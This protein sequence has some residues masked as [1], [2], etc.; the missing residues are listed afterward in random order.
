MHLVM[1]WVAGDSVQVYLRDRR[2]VNEIVDVFTQAARGLAAVHAAGFVH[3]DF[4]PENAIV[5]RDGRVRVLDF[6]LAWADLDRH[7]DD[8]AGTPRYMAPEQLTGGALTPAVD[9]YAL[10]VA[11]R[12]ALGARAG[13]GVAVDVPRWLAQI[14]ARGTAQRPDERF[15][16]LDE[17]IR[18][19]GRDPARVLRRRLAIASWIAA[20]VS[21]L[22][23]AWLIW[24]HDLD[25]C[26]TMPAMPPGWS[27]A[28]HAAV[29]VRL[30]TLGGFAVSQ[31]PALDGI[32]DERERGWGT[33]NRAACQAFTRGGVTA[34]IYE[35][36]LTCLARA[37]ASLVAAGELL[38][39]A[40]AETFPGARVAAGALI[41]P[42]RCLGVDS[43]AVTPPPAAI[44]AEVR[45]VETQIEGARILITAARPDAVRVAAE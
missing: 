6:G 40:T 41:D 27:A 16:S 5:G 10:C 33:A 31:K 19:L 45:A 44:A 28:S 43:S 13:E 42:A 25:P 23:G 37:G 3:R 12:D 14:I 26:A 39:G 34:G 7:A 1:E 35:R 21:L 15:A 29:D 11:L 9:Q 36:Q 18:A 4:K 2:T 8:V 38:A 20:P 22:L 32:L 24:N 30:G 17:V